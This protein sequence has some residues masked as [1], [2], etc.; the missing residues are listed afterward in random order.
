RPLCMSVSPPRR[1]SFPSALAARVSR[2]DGGVSEDADESHSLAPEPP[3]E[4]EPST[5]RS[6]PV[7]RSFPSALASRP[8][9]P[10]AREE[11]RPPL[12]PSSDPYTPVEE[13]CVS[14]EEEAEV[15]VVP[16]PCPPP[17]G[18]GIM[19]PYYSDP[20]DRHEIP[21]AEFKVHLLGCRLKHFANPNFVQMKRCRYNGSH[22]IPTP[23]LAMHERLCRDERRARIEQE[24]RTDPTPVVVYEGSSGEETSDS[25]DEYEIVDDEEEKREKEE[26][27]KEKGGVEE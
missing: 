6:P 17:S 22:Y 3:T 20:S 1:R 9:P 14:G 18:R 7:R 13:E 8:L 21:F 2:A 4:E 12:S 10:S 19:C 26:K 23:E 15:G 11:Q 16:S 25:D 24:I 5:S 27:E